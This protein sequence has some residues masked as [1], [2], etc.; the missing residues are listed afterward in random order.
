VGGCPVSVGKNTR[1]EL[2][3]YRLCFSL[4]DHCGFPVVGRAG[5]Q[6]R[7][8]IPDWHR[9]GLWPIEVSGGCKQEHG[10]A[11]GSLLSDWLSMT[12][13]SVCTHRDLDFHIDFHFHFRFPAVVFAPT[14]L[15]CLRIEQGVA[16]IWIGTDCHQ[17]GISVLNSPKWNLR[18]VPED[19]RLLDEQGSY[20][21]LYSPEKINFYPQQSR[22]SAFCNR[23]ATA[24]KPLC[25]LWS[26]NA[27]HFLST[28]C[29]CKN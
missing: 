10:Q 22:V 24:H 28:R 23:E 2:T 6:A 27:V 13:V 21:K 7:A 17:D 4:W 3:I 14:N 18:E 9:F 8:E 11:I 15:D 19:L 5:G 26:C 20:R 16:K 25:C 29:K 1:R 12:R